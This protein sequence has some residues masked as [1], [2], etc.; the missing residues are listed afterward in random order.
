MFQTYGVPVEQRDSIMQ[1]LTDS[2]DFTMYGI[3]QA[4]T[5]VANQEGIRDTIRET[6]MRVGGD[7]P[8]ANAQRCE[9]ARL[10]V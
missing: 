1:M 2:D 8:A 10:P 6:L 9:S 3:M 7:L 4:V 5:A